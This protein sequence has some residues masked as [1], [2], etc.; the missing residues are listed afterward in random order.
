MVY[1]MKQLQILS[2][3]IILLTLSSCQI[4]GDIFKT[5]VGVGVFLVIGVIALIIFIFAK[6]G[7]GGK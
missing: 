1:I 5:G 3:A 7:G 2:I 6:I 4:I